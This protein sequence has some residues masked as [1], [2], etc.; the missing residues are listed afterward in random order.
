MISKQ[1]VQMSYYKVWSSILSESFW[2]LHFPL[3]VKSCDPRGPCLAN[4]LNIQVSSGQSQAKG[5]PE[6]GVCPLSL[7]HIT[8]TPQEDGKAWP[9][10]RCGSAHGP[11]RYR[12]A[13]YCRSLERLLAGS[14]FSSGG[15]TAPSARDDALRF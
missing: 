15:R 5:L 8:C 7:P 14:C 1:I 2:H 12:K 4:R 13:L 6:P 10:T 3:L 11:I 9:L